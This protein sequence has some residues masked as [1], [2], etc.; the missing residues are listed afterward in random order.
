VLNLGW[1]RQSAV[2]RRIVTDSGSAAADPVATAA[3]WKFL[4]EHVYHRV[5]L[6]GEMSPPWDHIDEDFT[7]IDGDLQDSPSL[8]QYVA[9]DWEGRH[10]LLH[11]RPVCAAVRAVLAPLEQARESGQWAAH[12]AEGAAV[13][14]LLPLT[15]WPP[16]AGRRGDAAEVLARAATVRQGRAACVRLAASF[17][18]E[19]G[20]LPAALRAFFDVLGP[21]TGLGSEDLLRDRGD[22]MPAVLFDAERALG[23]IGIF[24]ADMAH[25]LD[26]SRA[27]S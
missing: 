8:A 27:S 7:E 26:Q 17:A 4:A 23:L 9:D 14:E 19:Q 20:H 24:L 22:F 3:V 25:T 18:D 6:A 1:F 15:P 5:E 11:P 16:P 10:L 13:D 21:T 2:P 12:P